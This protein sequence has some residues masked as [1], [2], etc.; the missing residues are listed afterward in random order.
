[1]RCGLIINAAMF[2]AAAPAQQFSASQ[3]KIGVYT[4]LAD[5]FLMW[6]GFFMII[7]LLSI[8][9]VE[10][11]GWAAASIGLVLAVRQFTQ[12]GLTLISGA[13]ADR[14]GAKGLILA[15]L[16]LR[17][18]GFAMMAWADNFP[19]LLLSAFLAA[20]GGS[21]FDSPK[22][23]AVVALTDEKD[24]P[25]FY[26]LNGVVSQ[27]GLTLGTQ[28]GALLI[29]FDFAIVALSAA[30]CFFLTFLVT[31]FF[32]PSVRVAEEGANFTGGIKLAISDRPFMLYNAILMGYWFMW[33]QISISLPLAAKGVGGGPDTVGWIYAINAALTI[34]LQ[35]PLLRLTARLLQPMMILICGCAFM[36][37][38]LG[39][40][41]IAG[42][43]PGLLLC[44]VIFAIGSLLAMP[45]QQTVTANLANPAALGSYF[46]VSSLALAFGGGLGN[47]SG[48]IL[49]D[50]GRGSLL[51]QLPWLVFMVVGLSSA[52]GLALM[53]RRQR[54]ARRLQGETITPSSPAG[55]AESPNRGIMGDAAK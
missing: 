43:V 7:P 53:E 55:E 29:Q 48:G 40:V 47:L 9:Y 22:N 4:L 41:A 27:V 52:L 8:Y 2:S 51:P 3:R 16:L 37:L 6:A 14:M 39:A 18:V 33:V 12:Q 21:M 31:L 10:K 46:G 34:V 19:L 20:V 23:A 15:G 28:L 49:Y 45:S 24:R 36:A 13:M 1:M 44:V 54:K 38:G 11:L 30:A 17:V 42:D 25:R 26:A 5:N 50:V 32:L 35:Y